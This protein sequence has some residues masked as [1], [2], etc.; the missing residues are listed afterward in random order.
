M[1]KIE[2]AISIKMFTE[3]LDSVLKTKL[4]NVSFK[5]ANFVR[6]ILHSH[7]SL[8]MSIAV[9]GSNLSLLLVLQGRSDGISAR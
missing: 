7:L 2:T 3:S 1:V 6:S 4:L 9:S 5:L 8:K